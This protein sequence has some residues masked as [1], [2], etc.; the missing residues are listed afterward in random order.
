MDVW[1]GSSLWLLWKSCCEY[2]CA[3]LLIDFCTPF[4]GIQQGVELLGYQV[5]S[6]VWL[7]WQRP[8]L[9]VVWLCHSQGESSFWW[10]K[11]TDHHVHIMDNGRRTQREV[12][13][14]PLP[15][16]DKP[17]KIWAHHFCGACMHQNLIHSPLP[18]KGHGASLFWE[19][20]CPYKCGG[21]EG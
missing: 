6:K 4:F 8:S 18:L 2:S 17:P 13:S 14:M 15:C 5:K 12:D 19:A 20:L 9:T 1:V 3:C 7:L 11:M 16:E 10:P 21:K